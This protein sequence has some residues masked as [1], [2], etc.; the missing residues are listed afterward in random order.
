[1]SNLHLD[2]DDLDPPIRNLVAVLNRFRGIRTSGSCGGH[3][4]PQPWQDGPGEWHV[5][6]HV[7]HSE[8]GWRALEFLAWIAQDAQSGG[9]Q[10]VILATAPPP[11]LN[12]PGRSLAFVLRGFDEDA[13]AWARTIVD[14][15]R[16]WYVPVRPGAE[17]SAPKRGSRV[18]RSTPQKRAR[19]AKPAFS[20]PQNKGPA[21]GMR[22]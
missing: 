9:H 3:E 11:Y 4:I 12:R 17:R 10:L 2:L 6:F 16:R 21:A 13:H 22:S 1:V 5:G 15:R 8:H 18:G 19:P 7:A 20:V 14:Y